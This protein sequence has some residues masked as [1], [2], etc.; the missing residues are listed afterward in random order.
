MATMQIGFCMCALLQGQDFVQVVWQ[1]GNSIF[2]V[3]EGIVASDFHWK[4]GSMIIFASR[5][6]LTRCGLAKVL[7]S[8]K[9]K[10]V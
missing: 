4:T 2:P 8:K 9:G 3:Q 1:R 7:P 6:E 10:A 5:G